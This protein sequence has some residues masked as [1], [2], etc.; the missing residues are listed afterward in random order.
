[1]RLFERYIFRQV[2][3]ATLITALLL[4]AI[5]W[6]TQ[7]LRLFDLLTAK[8]QSLATYLKITA[9]V[10]PFILL[11][12]IPIA[13]LIASLFVLNKLNG[14][15]EYINFAAAG[16]S[17][18]ATLRPFLYVAGVGAMVSSLLA[19]YLAPQSLRAMRHYKTQVVA[20]V[21]AKGL[22]PGQF[23]HMERDLVL[24]IKG[25]AKDG[26][27][28]QIF[29][30]DNRQG[31]VSSTYLAERG[32]LVR[33][34]IGT[35]LIMENGHIIQRRTRQQEGDPF[36]GGWQAPQDMGDAPGQ[37]IVS[38]QTYA[39]DLSQLTQREALP[40]FRPREFTTT[41]LITG[42]YEKTTR[43]YAPNAYRAE[44][45]DRLSLPLY[46]FAFV[47]IAFA[48][49]GRAQPAREGRGFIITSAVVCALL[50]RLG[51]YWATGLASNWPPA[52]AMMYAIPLITGVI[53]LAIIAQIFRPRVPPAVL[54]LAAPIK[55]RM[56]R[57]V[58]RTFGWRGDGAGP[59]APA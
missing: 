20:D 13:L 47:L 15:S 21:L 37:T 46:A 6:L 11:I 36:P 25:R 18:W 3:S 9:L 10:L 30:A 17:R 55:R 41:E 35:F 31:E 54:R 1:M 39:F 42:E 22:R 57:Y 8:G 27:F 26:A 50:I 14:D 49:L 53:A 28:Q 34:D 33:H 16:I 32:L 45:H 56:G 12:V 59:G 4:S 23:R 52:A 44:L 2:F 19:L 58:H 40:L 51:G 29:L 7:A 43:K 5:F 24:R 48:A 38:F